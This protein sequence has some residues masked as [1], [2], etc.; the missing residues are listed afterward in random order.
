MRSKPKSGSDRNPGGCLQFDD[1][2][3]DFFTECPVVFHE[4]H[5]RLT[6][7]QQVF[8]LNAGKYIDIIQRFIPHKEMGRFT[9]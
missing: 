6:G 8:Q 1:F 3:R 5:G 4:E 7:K 9:E 2:R